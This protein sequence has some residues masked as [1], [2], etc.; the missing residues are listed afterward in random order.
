VAPIAKVL[1]ALHSQWN[2][3][4]FFEFDCSHH[5]FPMT[6]QVSSEPD[7]YTTALVLV[8][9]LEDEIRIT[10]SPSGSEEGNSAWEFQFCILGYQIG[11]RQI[12]K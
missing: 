1:E 5:S 2:P 3:Y 9:H 4:R 8:S 11:K 7:H 10:Q 6:S 12:G